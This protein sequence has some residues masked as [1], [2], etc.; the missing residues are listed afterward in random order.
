MFSPDTDMKRS[1]KSIWTSGDGEWV[2]PNV[3]SLS[4]P[5]SLRNKR[6]RKKR[7]SFHHLF[8]FSSTQIFFS[9]TGSFCPL[10]F[11]WQYLWLVT[12]LIETVCMHM[13]INNLCSA[14]YVHKDIYEPW[15]CS[16]L[17]YLNK[18]S[19]QVTEEGHSLHQYY[20]LTE[21]TTVVMHYIN[22]V[23]WH[24]NISQR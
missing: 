13:H 20:V 24:R 6:L 11:C 5:Q 9:I 16:S 3:S 15:H 2:S 19:D 23:I 14:V 12:L 21:I 1:E 18:L 8:L 4:P 22:F 10:C 7:L 17:I